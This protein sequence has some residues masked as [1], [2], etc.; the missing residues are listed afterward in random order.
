MSKFLLKFGDI[1][2]FFL[3]I[4]KP[5]DAEFTD[6]DLAAIRLKAHLS[7]PALVDWVR[8]HDL[9][10]KRSV[11]HAEDMPAD[12]AAL[13]MI[14]PARFEFQQLCAAVQLVSGDF[15]KPTLPSHQPSSPTT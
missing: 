11:D 2:C 7:V 9:K 14:I 15:S 1:F 5:F 12:R 6:L 10:R 13:H 8:V 3:C 4:G